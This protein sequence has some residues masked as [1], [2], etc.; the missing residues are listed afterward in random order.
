MYYYDINVK[1][2]YEQLTFLLTKSCN[3]TCSYCTQVRGSDGDMSVDLFNDV[4][5]KTNS[6]KIRLHGGEPLMNIEVVKEALKHSVNKELWMTT[7]GYYADK[8]NPIEWMKFYTVGFS[9]DSVSYGEDVRTKS[10]SI[11]NKIISNIKYVQSIPDIKRVHILA[12]LPCDYNGSYNIINRVLDLNKETG[13]NI[14]RVSLSYNKCSSHDTFESGEVLTRYILDMIHAYI[15]IMENKLKIRL[16]FNKVE[17]TKPQTCTIHDKSEL[18][19]DSNG[20][21]GHCPHNHYSD[22]ISSDKFDKIDFNED[23]VCLYLTKGNK[24]DLSFLFHEIKDEY[25]D[26]LEK[27]DHINRDFWI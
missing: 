18:T 1:K 12:T 24:K 6:D 7:N 23:S 2:N 15:Y 27:L 16:M 25:R 8:L 11:L 21:V 5:N 14:F 9:I 20:L 13:V 4:L 17:I 10:K 19:I 3:L 22:P 26:I